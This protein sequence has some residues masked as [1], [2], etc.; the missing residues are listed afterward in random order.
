MLNPLSRPVPNASVVDVRQRH[1]LADRLGVD[2]ERHEDQITDIGVEI[3]RIETVKREL[4]PGT[5][6][7]AG[8]RL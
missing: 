3:D 7:S 4:S 2:V 8:R 6:G 1:P 5:D